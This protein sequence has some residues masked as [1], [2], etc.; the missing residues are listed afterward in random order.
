MTWLQARHKWPGLKSVLMVASQRE[1]AD[2]I[3]RE[4]LIE[5][6]P[7][8][9]WKVL[10]EP[11]HVERWFGPKTEIDLVEGGEARFGFP[12]HGHTIQ[13]RIERADEPRSFAWRWI[14]AGGPDATHL[15]STLVEFT[16]EPEGEGTRLHVAESGFT[17]VEW[18]EGKD[19]ADIFAG[20]IEGW[21]LHLR[22]LAELLDGPGGVPS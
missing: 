15:N 19:M 18:P 10:T 21:D 2:R 20:H 14:H 22:Q 16:L 1:F 7:E 13:A 8:V 9:V 4:T 5:A 3:E 11:R 12:E 17:G 6:P